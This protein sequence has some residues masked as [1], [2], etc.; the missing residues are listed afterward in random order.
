MDDATPFYRQP[1]RTSVLGRHRDR[2]LDLPADPEALGA[3]VRGL[4]IHDHT[5]A[6]QGLR[7]SAE[8]M[9]HREAVGA[10]AILDNV[11]SIDPAP[12][13]RERPVERRMFGFCYHFALL[14]CALLRATGT[15]ARI[16]CGFA[17]YFAAQ[18]WIDHW[19]VEYWDGSG[20][21][22][23]DPQTG[24][25]NWSGDDFQDGVTAWKL[26]RDGA[27]QPAAYGNGELW[28]W[29]ELRG[30]L[31]NDVG[32][33]SKVEVAGW[34]WCDRLRVEPLDQPHDELDQSLDSLAHLAA[35]AGS[36]DELVNCFDLYPEFRPPA[37]AV[38]R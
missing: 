5:A 19:V 9:S 6:V 8:R 2:V 33:L 3:I 16:R 34:Y 15:P 32:A 22:L 30:S 14:H 21:T 17:G 23:T 35:A 27:S 10:G 36:V 7:F 28:G 12:L 18:R 1:S 11:I 31:I 37:G 38:A 13:D 29:D 26:C 25:S 24:R 20:W 4:L